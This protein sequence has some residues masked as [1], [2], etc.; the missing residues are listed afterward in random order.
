[1]KF[2][3]VL[4]HVEKPKLKIST[5]SKDSIF[6]LHEKQ[7]ERKEKKVVRRDKDLIKTYFFPKS[8]DLLS[9]QPKF[10]KLRLASCLDSYQ[11]NYPTPKI[12]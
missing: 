7:G 11:S 3:Q 5:P 10:R 12:G 1:M 2:S 4:L 6:K 9:K 8:N